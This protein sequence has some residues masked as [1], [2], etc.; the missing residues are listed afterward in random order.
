MLLMCTVPCCAESLANWYLFLSGDKSNT[1][2]PYKPL[3]NKKF[4]L[5]VKGYRNTP[6]IASDIHNLGGVSNVLCAWT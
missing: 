3:L 1:R 2:L 5:D 4:Y 6:T